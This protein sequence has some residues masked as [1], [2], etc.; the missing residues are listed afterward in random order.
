[1]THLVEEVQVRVTEALHMG[2]SQRDPAIN[3]M[4]Q[5]GILE[6]HHHRHTN[7]TRLPQLHHIRDTQETRE[8]DI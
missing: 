4:S 7:R 6:A 5:E 1:M 2:E 3:A 8:I